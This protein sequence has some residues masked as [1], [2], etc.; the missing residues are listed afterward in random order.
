MKRST[1]KFIFNSLW[2]DGDNAC[3]NLNF[4]EINNPST[5][6]Q[7]KELALTCLD[8]LN[9]YNLKYS[10]QFRYELQYLIH[11]LEEE[12]MIIYEW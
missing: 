5:M 2:K 11:L 3:Y 1:I 10:G 7:Y 8:F 9:H 12:G 6:L 4:C